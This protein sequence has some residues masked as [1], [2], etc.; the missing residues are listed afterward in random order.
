MTSIQ[1]SVS[2][3]FSVGFPGQLTGMNRNEVDSYVNGEAS[4]AIDFGLAVM[5]GSLAK[6][7]LRAS[8]LDAQLLGIT[9]HTHATNTTGNNQAEPNGPVGVLVKGDVYVQP[10]V[11]VAKFDPVYV[12]VVAAGVEVLGALRNDADGGDA[13]RLPGAY[14]YTAGTASEPA[15]V[16]L[17]QDPS[18]AAVALRDSIALNIAN[19]SATADTTL[20]AYQ[21]PAGR[22][23]VIDSVVYHND[24]GLAQDA[25]NFFHLKVQDS[26]ATQVAAD[27][28]TETG[29]EGAIAADTPVA[30]TNGTLANRTFVAGTRI[31]VFLD[32]TG[33]Q[34]LPAGT[35]QINARL[36]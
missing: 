35:F 15:W 32:E 20:F 17:T 10:E 24:T 12:R 9:V 29:Q 30:L 4:E 13:I 34:T 19:A 25:A 2:Q 27:W 26:G 33:T 5:R 23:L 31:N 22:T 11:T 14:F 18:Q 8:G 36:V 21:V 28:S 7:A 6:E 1:T 16:R 3:N